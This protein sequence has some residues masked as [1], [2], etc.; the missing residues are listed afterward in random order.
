[1]TLEFPVTMDVTKACA[2]MCKKVQWRKGHCHYKAS[3]GYDPR[4][5]RH[6]ERNP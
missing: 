1:M 3:A 6:R 5:S 4:R 2:D